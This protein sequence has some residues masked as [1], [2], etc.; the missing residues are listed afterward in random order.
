MTSSEFLEVFKNFLDYYQPDKEKMKKE[1]Q[2]L[3]FKALKDLDVESFKIG[4]VRLV[5]DR[6][7][8]NFPSIAEIRKYSLGLKDEDIR[9]R[10]H[11]S[12]EKVKRAI[13]LY[14]ANETVAFDDPAIHAVIESFG[15]WEKLC[16]VPLKDFENF[17]TFEFEKIYR[18]YLQAPYSVPTKFLGI[19][20][21]KN[22]EENLFILGEREKYIEWKSKLGNRMNLINDNAKLK[23]V[24]VTI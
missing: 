5:S 11:L 9:V 6:E 24:G 16:I 7:Y 10:V 2:T 21:K 19:F 23:A 8:A 1:K 13:R 12:K 17:F 4:F 18:A 15:G 22:D 20:D 3:Y 14:G